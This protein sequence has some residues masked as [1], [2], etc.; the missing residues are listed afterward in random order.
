MTE[1]ENKVTNYVRVTGRLLHDNKLFDRTCTQCKGMYSSY[2]HQVCP[3]CGAP[4]TFITT[5][6]GVPMAISEGTIS[7]S[8]GEG[9]RKRVQDNIQYGPYVESEYRFKIINFGDKDGNL[10]PPSN[11]K[12]FRKGSIIE[13]CLVNHPI[14]VK[15]PFTT[16]EGKVKVELMMNVYLK[17]GDSVKV[18]KQAEVAEATVSTPVKNPQ[19]NNPNQNR[20]DNME[21]NIEEMQKTLH[22]LVS[23]MT[24]NQ[25]VQTQTNESNSSEEGSSQV[26]EWPENCS[27]DPF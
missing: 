20:I 8:L 6:S 10:A 16:K 24:G 15:K 19:N 3:K 22:V 1:H 23:K 27:F 9:T 11:H 13:V 5:N 25:Q 26:D 7:M 12:N 18:L 4:L 14:E 21:K 2:I 17:Y